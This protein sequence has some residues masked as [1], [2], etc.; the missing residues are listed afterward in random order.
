MSTQ[1]L[2]DFNGYTIECP[3]V[4]CHTAYAKDPKY[5]APFG[6]IRFIR[7]SNTG[8]LRQA[9]DG[10]YEVRIMNPVSMYVLTESGSCSATDS[11]IS[12]AKRKGTTEHIPFC[13]EKLEK[14]LIPFFPVQPENRI[15]YMNKEAFVSKRTTF[16]Y[17]PPS[18]RSGV[19]HTCLVELDASKVSELISTQLSVIGVPNSLINQISFIIYNRL[20]Q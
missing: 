17:K 11:L 1:S 5:N 19:R 18:F 9:P 20:N 10:T 13:F 12:P 2:S 3:G 7:F 14:W 4:I 16:I 8:R 15:L 6:V